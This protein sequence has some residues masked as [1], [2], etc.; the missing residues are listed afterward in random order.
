M[1][2]GLKN[3]ISQKHK[4]RNTGNPGKGNPQQLNP[5]NLKKRKQKFCLM[6]GSNVLKN[7]IVRDH[8]IYAQSFTEVSIGV[9]SVIFPLKLIIIL[10]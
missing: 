5:V 4:H 7:K 9:L 6:I 2:V 1:M 3:Q 10:K 8:I